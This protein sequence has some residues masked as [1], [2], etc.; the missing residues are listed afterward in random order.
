MPTKPSKALLLSA[1]TALALTL[2]VLGPFSHALGVRSIPAA[3]NYCGLPAGWSVPGGTLL[4]DTALLARLSEQSAVLLGERHD[5]LEHHR[6]QLDVLR[7]LHAVH[8]DIALA[9]EMFPR[10]VQPALDAWVEGELSEAE[11]LAQSDWHKVWRFDPELYMDIFRFAR[12]KRIPMRAVNVE[13]D[14]TRLVGRE[15][16][17]AVPTDEL[18]GVGRPAPPSAAY[19]D[20]LTTIYQMHLV[21]NRVGEHSER[22]LRNFIEAQLLWDRSMAEGIH[23]AIVESPGRL[24]VALIGSGHL[25]HGHGVPHQLAD[26]G[27]S[28]QATL[29]PWD[30]DFDCNELVDGLADAVYNLR[31]YGTRGPALDV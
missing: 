22:H 3:G 11:F 8:P 28:A 2:G 30:A 10:R 13:S 5:R 4:E 24:V 21:G 27:V 16:F 14:L 23:G 6:W 25:R 18:E 31:D 26:L 12:D 7:A 1:I 20:W 15:G 9:L 17:D 29:L 19:T